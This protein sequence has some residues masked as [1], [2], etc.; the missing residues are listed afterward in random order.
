MKECNF[1]IKTALDDAKERFLNFADC[2]SDYRWDNIQN[3]FSIGQIYVSERG[4]FILFE[5]I[6]G[7]AFWG[8]DIESWLQL[9]E[10]N[11]LVYACY[12]ESQLNAEF[13]EIIDGICVQEF[14]I[15]EGEIDT[16]MKLESASRHF[17]HWIDVASF[18]DK[19]LH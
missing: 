4:E 3:C 7:E 14:R 11:E 18:M 16:D 1:K 17:A 8:L 5:D 9:A 2:D 10:T 15:Y 13:I 19:N 6:D 12:D